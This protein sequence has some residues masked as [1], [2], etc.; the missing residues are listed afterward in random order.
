[1]ETDKKPKKKWLLSLFAVIASLLMCFTFSLNTHIYADSSKQASSQAASSSSGSSSGSSSS[2]GTASQ[3]QTDPWTQA[4]SQLSGDYSTRPGD[5]WPEA[6]KKTKGSINLGNIYSYLGPQ[7]P[8]FAQ[9]S[10]NG[11]ADNFSSDGNHKENAHGMANMALGYGSA[12]Y[13]V[14][15]DHPL[16]NSTVG[17]TRVNLGRM[18]GGTCY[19]LAYTAVVTINKCFSTLTG[20]IKYVNVLDWLGN[21]PTNGP[22]G[23]L[24]ETVKGI[25]NSLQGLG[26]VFWS[27]VLAVLL[28]L[29]AMGFRFAGGNLSGNTHVDAGPMFIF[30]EILHFAFRLFNFLVLPLLLAT[31][32]DEILSDAGSTFQHDTMAATTTP[33]YSTLVDF[34]GAVQHSR[35]DL[36]SSIKLNVSFNPNA[37]T[38]LS[39]SQVC[40][41]NAYSA[42]DSAA[43]DAQ[44]TANNYNDL[45]SGSGDIDACYHL[46]SEW[47]HG[48]EY[49]PAD[50]VS[51]AEGHTSDKYL[52][53]GT[54]K[55]SS[56]S[57]SSD[58][59]SSSGVT[60]D[61]D[62]TM[63]NATPMAPNT[64]NNQAGN[65]QNSSSQES[66]LDDLTG[67]AGS[68][69]N[70]YLYITNGTLSGKWGGTYSTAAPANDSSCMK[71]GSNAGGLSTLGMYNFL[72]TN[73][74]DSSA[75]YETNAKDQTTY[76][77]VSHYEVGIAGRGLAAFANWMLS[78][79]QLVCIAIFGVWTFIAVISAV[80]SGMTKALMY[81]GANALGA[82]QGTIKLVACC[83]MLIIEFVGTSF[84]YIIGIH[85]LLGASQ[86]LP[87]IVNSS[88]QSSSMIVQAS[89]N[90][91][92]TTGANLL[93]SVAL[94]WLTFQMIRLRGVI[95]KSFNEMAESAVRSVLGS[96]DRHF[97]HSANLATNEAANGHTYN[98][99]GENDLRK[100]ERDSNSGSG[101]PGGNGANGR[102]GRDGHGSIVGRGQ[103]QQSPKNANPTGFGRF[104]NYKQGQKDAIHAKEQELNRHL[105]DA[106]KKQVKREYARQQAGNAAYRIAGKAADAIGS[107]RLA[108]ALMGHAAN[109]D[110][111]QQVQRME[112]AMN[113]QKLRENGAYAKDVNEL[114]EFT[115]GKRKDG[116]ID[117]DAQETK[118]VQARNDAMQNVQDAMQGM[119]E[120]VGADLAQ[121]KAEDGTI[122]NN[123]D[124]LDATEKAMGNSMTDQFNDVA[125]NGGD[126]QQLSDDV[127]D[128][129]QA[130][131]DAI[132]EQKQLTDDRKAALGSKDAQ[133]KAQANTPEAEAAYKAKLAQSNEKINQKRAELKKAQTAARVA[134]GASTVSAS[135]LKK[136]T[137]KSKIKQGLAESQ[138]K[139]AD[140]RH[141][142]AKDTAAQN[143]KHSASYVHNKQNADRF[144][145][146]A[147]KLRNST[148]PPTVNQANNAL[149]NIAKA[150]ADLNHFVQSTNGKD[151]KS[152]G[153]TFAAYT[154]EQQKKLN[155]KVAAVK[156]AEKHADAIG[157]APETY[158]STEHLIQNTRTLNQQLNAAASGKTL[159]R[160]MNTHFEAHELSQNVA[161]QIATD[162]QATLTNSGSTQYDRFKD[163]ASSLNQ[164]IK[165]AANSLKRK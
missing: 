5:P 77:G 105:T 114:D 67:K 32:M 24:G 140:M 66:L 36:P 119:S 33:I 12:L 129:K 34:K 2:S 102:N 143:G 81:L 85:L 142:I 49:E 156:A 75:T 10:V 127:H 21:F 53:A 124:M 69:K 80:F 138:Q 88:G 6:L 101:M 57:D 47:M 152:S 113:G 161:D 86:L 107:H 130:L 92:F 89:S 109:R 14:G 70:Q 162:H 104:T 9:N 71:A 146:S 15:L 74:D 128:K 19:L 153:V 100:V 18:L 84:F 22:F 26:I 43:R 78:L 160:G 148:T 154:P 97:N 111:K 141:N 149:R 68:G 42:G 99:N 108:Q 115:N 54:S 1:M 118:N 87:E 7:N 131:S 20:W 76:D 35:L 52:E 61:A 135:M 136:P 147:N 134:A 79:S 40:D 82:L 121:Q 110:A 163:S 60:D 25:V 117:N 64:D 151:N 56:S 133:V 164:N 4:V 144:Q 45:D 158:D 91:N 94:F 11:Y 59:S 23:D 96:P 48:Y 72:A 139:G 73:F 120:Q 62:M 95:M 51:Y 83:V 112:K 150:R 137:L 39:Q 103:F 44:T 122:A 28:L 165:D 16:A 29:G 90:V 98:R 31:A 116:K 55:Q 30:D 46:I 65:A 125:Q 126:L 41:F 17:K 93:T 3:E 145:A 37:Q 63:P 123:Q 13:T 50:F 106:E 38:T 157:L 159:K 132:A 27:F 155:A 8:V 58:S